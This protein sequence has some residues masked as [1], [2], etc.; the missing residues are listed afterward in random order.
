MDNSKN[1]ASGL[2]LARPWFKKFT[3]KAGLEC[4][5]KPRNALEVCMYYLVRKL[6]D[7]KYFIDNKV[8]DKIFLWIHDFLKICLP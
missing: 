1:L 6:F 8:H 2:R 7:R 3:T 4:T 5:E